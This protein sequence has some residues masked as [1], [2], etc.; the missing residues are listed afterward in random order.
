[1]TNPA[2]SSFIRPI[3]LRK[4]LAN[5]A[6]LIERCFFETMD[7]EGRDYVRNVRQIARGLG[8]L[9]LERTTPES[10][11]LPFHGYVWVED[12]KIIG[13]LTLIVVRRLSR[14]TYLI[15][16][17][18]VTPEHRGRGIAQAL[19]QR[20][21]EHIRSNGG[22]KVLLQVRDDNPAAQHIYYSNGFSED[23]RRTTWVFDRQTDPKISIEPEV[24]ISRRKK[25]DWA[26]QR[27]WLEELYPKGVAWNLPFDLSRMRPGFWTW[28]NVFMMGG[29]T[30]TWTARQNGK[31][32]GSAT[33][34]SG[35]ESVDFIWLASSPAYEQNAF[36][37]LLPYV[38][39]RAIN[40][41]RLHVNYPYLRA[42]EAFLSAGFRK[43]NTLIWMS[44]NIEENNPEL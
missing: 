20:A 36:A 13:N 40:P 12:G 4:D 33:Y 3:E 7:D 35:L 27:A 44:K 34:E 19:T 32:L 43:Q 6:D 2:R 14:Q 26:Q 18:A 11:P 10:S 25:D 28:M 16:N 39:K 31:L 37:Q 5:V 23:F 15:A 38:I 21:L 24:K 41:R 1:M 29:S 9:Y 17:V 42:E 8:G 30:S 22:K